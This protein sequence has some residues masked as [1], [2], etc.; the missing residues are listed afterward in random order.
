M[1]EKGVIRLVGGDSPKVYAVAAIM[2][3]LL[4]FTWDNK[5]L[6]LDGCLVKST[7]QV[8]YSIDLPPPNQIIVVAKA[9]NFRPME[10]V[11][12]KTNAA[13]SRP[14]SLLQ[15]GILIGKVVQIGGRGEKLSAIGRKTNRLI[16]QRRVFLTVLRI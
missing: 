3:E 5:I 2:T 8:T 9:I 12:A 4:I 14:G 1:L 10:M 6:M 16:H 11:L 15:T 13:I 7:I